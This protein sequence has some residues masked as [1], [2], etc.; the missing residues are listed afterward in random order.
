M[1]YSDADRREV[2]RRAAQF[3]AASVADIEDAAREVELATGERILSRR[4][5]LAD[6]TRADLELLI[7]QAESGAKALREALPWVGPRETLGSVVKT[8]PPHIAFE[9]T[10]KLRA[11]GLDV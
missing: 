6:A 3:L 9:L 2:A 10:V 8:L 11:A 5:T 1:S 7:V 4:P